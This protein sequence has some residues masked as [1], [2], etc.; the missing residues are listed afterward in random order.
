MTLE[1]KGFL[2]TIKVKGVSAYGSTPEKGKNA[3]TYIMQFLRTIID[4]E[5]MNY[6]SKEAVFTV[7]VFMHFEDK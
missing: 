5:C 7:P 6:Q 4:C 1:R 3:T 2:F